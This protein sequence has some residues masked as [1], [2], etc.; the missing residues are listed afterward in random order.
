MRLQGRRSAGAGVFHVLALLSFVILL[1]F[2][3]RGA[4]MLLSLLFLVSNALFSWYTVDK[5]YLFGWGYLASTALTLVASVIVLRLRLANL[6]YVT[7]VQ[8]P[9]SQQRD[10]R[11]A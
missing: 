8:Q 7:F 2:D 5:P 9:V 3:F 1:Y 4:V 10:A 6:E 11:R